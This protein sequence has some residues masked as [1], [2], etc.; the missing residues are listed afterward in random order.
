MPGKAGMGIAGPLEPAARFELRTIDRPWLAVT[1]QRHPVAGAKQ[2]RDVVHRAPGIVEAWHSCIISAAMITPMIHRGER[3]HFGGRPNLELMIVV[4][5]IGIIA[6]LAIPA[7][8]NYYLKRHGRC[9]DVLLTAGEGTLPADSKCP[10]TDQPYQVEKKP[11][12]DHLSCPGNH[13]ATRP[14]V[15]R[16]AGSYEVRQTLP[17]YEGLSIDDW[18]RYAEFAENPDGAV[19]EIRPRAWY[20]WGVGPVLILVALL[21]GLGAIAQLFEAKAEK[22]RGQMGCMMAV[23]AI[24][25]LLLVAMLYSMFCVERIELSR[26]KHAVA[27]RSLVFGRELFAPATFEDVRA[28]IVVTDKKCDVEVVSGAGEKRTRTALFKVTKDKL[29][30]LGPLNAAIGR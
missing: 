5:I 25:L 28:I 14:V 20:R 2:P 24:P 13:L 12:G 8:L 21:T 30:I 17:A 22:N 3:G 19:I 1:R 10:V 29:G 23:M 26:S 7:Y 11:E 16:T 9:L 6:A 15:V 4:A 18:H 27:Q